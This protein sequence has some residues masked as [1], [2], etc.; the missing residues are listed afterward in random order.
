MA[1]SNFARSVGVVVVVEL[2]LMLLVG[3]EGG[4][5]QRRSGADGTT[6]TKAISET[7]HDCLKVNPVFH[8]QPSFSLYS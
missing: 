8:K 7:T 2:L 4:G 5:R 6:K 1:S 3:N